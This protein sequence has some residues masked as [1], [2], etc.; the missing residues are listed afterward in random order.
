[1]AN[2]DD[3][4][5]IIVGVRRN[6]L[7]GPIVLV[8]LGG[9]HTELLQDTQCALGPVTPATA[10]AML[11]RLRGAPVFCGFRG[12]PGVDVAA[13]GKLVSSLSW[14]AAAHPEISEIECNPVAVGPSGAVALD[15]RII[16]VTDAES[17]LVPDSVLPR[18]PPQPDPRL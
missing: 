13:A 17:S 5:E 14:F 10:I 6:S 11:G 9:V 1:M 4:V 16:L 7:F 2:L 8:G 12:R 18:T 15:A 3:A